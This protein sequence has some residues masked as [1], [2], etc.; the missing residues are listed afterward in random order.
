MPMASEVAAT[1]EM[2]RLREEMAKEIETIGSYAALMIR[3]EDDAEAIGMLN[4][5]VSKL[6]RL[7]RVR[8]SVVNTL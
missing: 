3:N 8:S 2:G 6:L 5:F 4:G 1:S 7:G